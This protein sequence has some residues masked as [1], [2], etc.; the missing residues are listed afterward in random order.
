MQVKL[1]LVLSC[2]S[3][4]NKAA[5]SRS[6]FSAIPA[7]VVLRIATIHC[8]NCTIRSSSIINRSRSNIFIGLVLTLIDNQGTGGGAELQLEVLAVVLAVGGPVVAAGYG[9]LDVVVCVTEHCGRAVGGF[10]SGQG[11]SGVLCALYHVHFVGYGIGIEPI[12]IYIS[13]GWCSISSIVFCLAIYIQGV[14]LS[15]RACAGSQILKAQCEWTGVYMRLVLLVY[16]I[17]CLCACL[18]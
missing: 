13:C 17:K 6:S 12:V 4:F 10:Y 8:S 18:G 3:G 5:S 11:A 16:G 15:S 1:L 14:V 7:V 2:N 9:Q